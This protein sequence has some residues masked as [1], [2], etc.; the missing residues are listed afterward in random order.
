MSA[1]P[2]VAGQYVVIT[3]DEYAD[4]LAL[5]IVAREL[6]RKRDEHV[7]RGGKDTTWAKRLPIGSVAAVCEL[8]GED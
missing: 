8:A 2:A 5:R 4:L 6:R 7:A 3:T 1:P